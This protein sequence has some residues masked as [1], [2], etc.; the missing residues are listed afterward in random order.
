M[1]RRTVLLVPSDD[2]GWT[3]LRRALA[4]L[5]DVRL[6]GEAT[7]ARRALDLALDL[8]LESDVCSHDRPQAGCA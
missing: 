3:D 4:A 6:V 7:S 5:P 2:C 1:Q 8:A